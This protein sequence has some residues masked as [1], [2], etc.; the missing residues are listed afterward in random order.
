M[1]RAG[2]LLVSLV[3]KELICPHSS[4]GH[5]SWP[6]L[7]FPFKKIHLSCDPRRACQI[8]TWQCVWIFLWQQKCD[9]AG[10]DSDNTGMKETEAEGLRHLSFTLKPSC[11]WQVVLVVFL[12]PPLR[13]DHYKEVWQPLS[14]YAD[15]PDRSVRWQSLCRYSYESC[16]CWQRDTDFKEDV[17]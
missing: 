3:N 17:K 6:S 10:D 8:R 12:Q 2:A 1:L 13:W 7:R 9:R 16:G 5:L 14:T 11:A 15:P 4:G